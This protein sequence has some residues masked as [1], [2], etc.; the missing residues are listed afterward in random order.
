MLTI[1]KIVID[2][3]TKDKIKFDQECVTQVTKEIP[4]ESVIRQACYIFFNTYNKSRIKD[5]SIYFLT[6]LY[7]SFQIHK[8]LERNR[9]NL[10]EEAYLIQCCYDPSQKYSKIYISSHQERLMLTRNAINSAI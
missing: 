10:N 7:S 2:E 3:H 1:A 9:L 8:V 5:P 4:P 6:L